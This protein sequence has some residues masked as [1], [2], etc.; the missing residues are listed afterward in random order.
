[1]MLKDIKLDDKYVQQTGRVFMT[2]SQA[3]ARLPMLQQQRDRAAGLNTA[4]FISGYR[5]SPLGGLD[6]TLWQAQRFLLEH[7]IHFQ[8]GVNEDLAATSVWG[9][10]QVN[11]FAGAKFDGVFAMWYGKGPGVD[12]SGDVF[13][14]ANHAGTSK[15][16]G[17]LAVAGDDHGCKSSTLPHQTEYAFMD[18]MIP[19]L[20]P[21]GVQEIIDFGL[22]GWAM[23]RFS[24][25]WVALKTIAETVDA[26]FSTDID[27]SRIQMVYPD[28]P[29]TNLHAR[30]PDKPLEQELRLHNAKLDA[31]L[32]FAQANNLNRVTLDTQTPR[33]GIVSTG[34]SWLDVMQALDD[35]GI[36]D[37]LA[38]QIGLRV[39]K[40]GMS[41]PLEPQAM[42]D[43]AK[44]LDEVLVVEEKRGLIEDQLTSQLYN[45]H[46]DI[47]P[48]VVGKHDE[49]GR[50]LLPATG[51]LTPAAI[52]RVIAGRITRFFTSERMD[53]RLQFLLEKEGYLNR[54]KDL[55]ER[56]PHFC[57]GCPHNTST[58][59][60][61]GSRAMGGIGCHY[62]ATWM[63]RETD[64]FTQM[65]GEGATWIGQAPFTATKHVFQN[66]GDGTY[67][68][69]GLL[70]IRAAIASKHNITYKILYNDAVAMT[71]GQAVD[72][73]LSVPQVCHQVR[74]EGVERIAV[75]S[76]DIDKYTRSEFP[77]G[78]SFDH[79]DDLDAVQC[80]LREYAGTS[81][82]IYDQTC[83]AEKRRRR[84][85]G[86]M[87]DPA[88]RAV[89]NTAVCEG[90]GDCGIA[91]NCLSLVPDETEYGRKR[92]IEQSSCNKDMS[93]V[94]G[95]CP[96]FVS[97]VGGQLR[98]PDAT[99]LTNDSSDLPLPTLPGLAEPYGIVLAGVGGTGV[100]TL[101]AI[102]GTAAHLEGNGASVLDMAGLAQKFGAVITHIQIATDP[103]QVHATRIAAGGA[104]LIIGCD[105]V[106][107]ASNDSL[108]KVE[109]NAAAAIINDHEAMTAD[110]TRNADSVFP[111]GSMHNLIEECVGKE[112]SHF[113]NAT[114]AAEQ[115]L[116][117][118]MAANILLAGYAWQLGLIPI[119]A[120]AI[121][122]AIELN[123]ASVQENLQAFNLGRRL[124][125]EPGF[126]QLKPA[127]ASRLENLETILADR[128]RF[129]SAYQNVALADRYE[130][131]V[132][133]FQAHLVTIQVDD[134]GLL[135]AL[136]QNYFKLLAYKD[137]Y[138]VA[139]LYTDGAFRQSVAAQ[140]EGNYKLQFHL[141]PPLLAPRDKHTGLPR[142]LTF[143]GWMMPVFSLLARLRWLRGTALDPF[144]YT[145]DR[146]LERQLISDYENL[147]DECLEHLQSGNLET[148]KA[149]LALP[150]QIRGFG[151]V[152][153]QH[154]DR[155]NASKQALLAKLDVRLEV[156]RIVN[157]RA[158]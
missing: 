88:L 38:S 35:L 49:Q 34:K 31:A 1:M 124:A 103:E 78:T 33:L 19:V 28:I 119:S 53:K 55:I 13:K 47:R 133:Q 68:H 30:W 111:A 148:I 73:Q 93:C 95:F 16:G 147:L 61:A 79:R 115:L 117:S 157:P 37:K 149:L 89:I 139:R 43:F 145:A 98:K 6:K 74:A 107:A 122:R 32:A 83:A 132:R 23:S 8:P 51:E 63:D 156:V 14:H 153:Q 67:F 22:Y 84:K 104:Q 46:T 101:G 144:G 109:N 48:V 58:R 3:L 105:L 128:R 64:T 52:A 112:Q 141:A 5:G 85:K 131:R 92:K 39:M 123:G 130:A 116:G 136:A 146:Q 70:A 150:E 143:G 40:V 56:V 99:L 42:R 87:P 66:L 137:E 81:I 154:V 69:S 140:F 65:G 15:F 121:N 152:K 25:C 41:W 106:V 97:V 12:R 29:E 82:L 86:E 9:S 91:S 2:G 80:E 100:T 72:G 7:N 21:A 44:G 110:F 60:P 27:L 94:K 113:F 10:Q 11:I 20:N 77:Q 120:E 142:K 126:G 24:G 90:C 45:W 71:G 155:A 96:S 50:W 108:V 76:D 158:A 17:V 151:H 134:A 102:L 62:M 59:V 18:A 54:P 114:A 26:S 138:E 75:V 4:G 125:V 57:S 129:L 135:V 36:D 127:K 118:T